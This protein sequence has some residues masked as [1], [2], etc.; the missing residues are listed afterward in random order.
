MAGRARGGRG[1]AGCGGHGRTAA[2]CLADRRPDGDWQGNPGIP[3]CPLAACRLSRNP[4]RGRRH[5][6]GIATGGRRNPCRPVGGRPFLRR[7]APTAQDGDRRRRRAADRRFPSPHGRGGRLE[8][9]D[10][11]RRRS[12]EPPR[13]QRAAQDPGGAAATCRAGPGQQQPGPAA[14]HHT[15]PVPPSAPGSARP[16][17]DDAGTGTPAAGRKRGGPQPAGQTRPWCAG[18]GGRACPRGRPRL[19]GAGTRPAGWWRLRRCRL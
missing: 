16:T 10:P 7:E 9:G 13:R 14:S 19:G 3:L 2:S 17:A 6:S 15:Q 12:P 18:A 5:R 1:D 4:T 8:G 11:G